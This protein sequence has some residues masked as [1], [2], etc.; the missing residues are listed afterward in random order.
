MSCEHL[1]LLPQRIKK[2]LVSPVV[3]ALPPSGI[4]KF[5]DLVIGVKGVISLGVG[6]P[7]FVTPWHIREACFYHLEQGYTMYTSN[8]GMLELRRE[9]ASYLVSH[10]GVN[11]HADDQILV[12]LGASEAV[13]LA[14]RSILCPG[15]EVLVPEPCYVSYK[16]CT[17]LAG[18]KP[19]VITTT[20]AN[21]F[22]PLPQQIKERITERSRVLILCFPNNPTGATMTY[23]ELREIAKIVVEHDLLVISDEIYAA[24]TYDGSHVCFASL[25]GMQERTV[26]INGFSK[27]FA[28]TGWRVGFAAAPTVLINAMVK[29][30]Q[31]TMICAP[32][33]GQ[34]AA[35]EALRH[36][37]HEVEKMVNQYNQRRRLIL[38][39]LRDMGLEC[40]EPK[41]AFYVFP[42]IKS[43]G[44][45]AEE[46]CQRLLQE[47]KVAVVPG[48][49][50]G[51]SGE[52]HIRCSY[53]TS[54]PRI[55]EAMD[56][57]ERFI[58]R[59]QVN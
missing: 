42:S 29:I 21:D 22:K 10:Y 6:E 35:L 27:A 36:G 52:G 56:R 3:K 5:F 53:A 34:M 15:D 51:E 44:M 19:V 32:V 12:T 26:L 38:R 57:M 50:F 1:H 59:Y 20:A 45:S 2:E 18:G 37:A 4:R 40:F 33:M 11:Y 23:D 8:Y 39:R 43:T 58:K 41:G 49:A 17:V 54:V 13:D 9:I 7:D 14:L 48:T 47:E 16:P 25:P 31:Y 28:M 24:L 30:H 55:S 46:F